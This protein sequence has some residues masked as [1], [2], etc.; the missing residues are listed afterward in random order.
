MDDLEGTHHLKVFG[1]Y[2]DKRPFMSSYRTEFCATNVLGD[3]L[4]SRYLQI[5][6]VLR[7]GTELG[8]IDIMTNVS[9]L[10]KH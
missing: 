5:I 4:Q 9:V 10:F 7:W 6:V 2:A 8:I 3:D 1:T